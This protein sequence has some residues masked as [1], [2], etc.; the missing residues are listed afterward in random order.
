MADGIYSD[1]V[2][3]DEAASYAAN[4]EGCC[5][6]LEND[7]SMT[8]LR[9]MA[10]GLRLSPEQNRHIKRSRAMNRIEQLEFALQDDKRLLETAEK[11]HDEYLAGHLRLRVAQ[12]ER[13][14]QTIRNTGGE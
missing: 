13:D 5:H 9:S 7:G 11:H 3:D 2:S 4:Y 14:I 8:Y 10:R 1:F 12:I 6:R